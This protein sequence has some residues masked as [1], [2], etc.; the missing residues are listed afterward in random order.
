MAARSTLYAILL[1]I[2][3]VLSLTAVFVDHEEKAD[4]GIV[5]KRYEVLDVVI[6][7][8][9]GI[10]IMGTETHNSSTYTET[11][12]TRDKK[13]CTQERNSPVLH[14]R[15]E[16]ILDMSWVLMIFSV[17]LALYL[18]AALAELLFKTPMGFI[19]STETLSKGM[20]HKVAF[21]VLQVTFVILIVGFC[22]VIDYGRMH[23]VVAEAED[24]LE[25]ISAVA[26]GEEKIHISVKY[27]FQF[28]LCIAA[29]S[30]VLWAM[31]L[32]LEMVMQKNTGVYQAMS[33]MMF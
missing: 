16:A 33:K 22:M 4:H 29:L 12:K 32:S 17:I 10:S 31:M 5:Q 23:K 26:L 28:D 15:C 6:A 9:Y 1:L 8:S 13:L 3:T 11:Y 19:P 18:V 7:D 2:A 14:K 27:G 30:F 25:E 24:E 20:G 21:A